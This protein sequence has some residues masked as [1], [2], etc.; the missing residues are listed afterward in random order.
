MEK[1]M[2]RIQKL[3]LPFSEKISSVKYLRALAETMQ[4]LMPVTVIG[5]FACLFAFIDIG[6]WQAFLA[7]HPTVAMIFMNTHSLTLACIAFYV[8][9]VLPYRYAEY[10]GM[11]ESVNMIPLTMAAFL[12]LTPT[13]LYTAVPTEWLGFKGMFSAMIIGF[14]V[15]KICKFFVDKKITIKMPAGVPKFIEDTF[16]VLIP[17]IVI[18]AGSAILGQVVA[19]TK[20]GSVHNVIYTLI[21]TPL[22]G[23]GMSFPSLLLAEILM[24]LFM[25]CGIHGSTAVTYTAP[26]LA[27]ANAENMAAMAAGQSMPNIWTTGLMN[28]IQA[29]GIGATLGLA[30]VLVIFA[31]SKRYKQLSRMAIVPQI[32]NIGEPLLFGIP[33]MLNPLLFIP[34]MGGVIVNTFVA[35]FSVAS[36]LVARFN[37]VDVSWTLPTGIQGL[38]SNTKPIEGLI[39]QLVIVAIDMLIWYPFVKIIDKQALKEEGETKA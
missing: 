34:Y 6:P 2:D 31:K 14:L 29:G 7:A 21:Q 27:A 33:I 35:Y 8:V 23:I 9:M 19:G 38:L 11:K 15:P 13:Q 30:I 12:L 18:I 39:L 32:F 1:L 28:S 20:I 26:L 25:F 5:S 37:G 10:L 24:T 17:A 4:I 22:Q 3:V 36:G 16:S